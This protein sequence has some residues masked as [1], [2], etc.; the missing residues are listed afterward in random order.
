[1]SRQLKVRLLGADGEPMPESALKSLYASDLHFEPERRRSEIGSDG[2]VEIEAPDGPTA[3]HAKVDV[4]GFGLHWVTADN[5]GQGF[6]PSDTEIDFVAAAAASRLADVK[7]VMAEGGVEWSAPC[8]AH[9]DGAEDQLAMAGAASGAAK[10]Q[11]NLRSLSHGLW[12]GELAVV[13]R[14]QARIAAQGAREGLLFG[15]NAFPRNQRLAEIRARFSQAL[16][17]ATLPFYLARLEPEEGKPD[18]SR[19]DEILAW[20]E[21]EGITPKGHPL[22][23]GNPSGVPKWLEGAD[24]ETEQR[25]CRRV[26]SRSVERYRDRIKIWDAINE[27]HDWANGLGHT[28]E[29]AVEIT[30]IACET[31][32]ENQPDAT[33]IVNNCCPFGEY[34]ASGIVYSGPVLDPVRTP[35]GYMQA[36]M[37]AD[38]DFDVVGVQ[39]YFQARDM[40]AISKLLDEYARFGKRVHITELGIASE[41]GALPPGD[42]REELARVR[43]SWHGPWSERNQADWVEWF[44]TMC[45][46]RPEMEAITWWD[47]AD[48]AFI[49][50]AGFLREDATPK[51]SYY[52][53]RGLLRSWGF[54]E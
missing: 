50:S 21:Q 38:F 41:E 3:L 47:I 2:T 27:A 22:W 30:R 42:E 34:A 16:N 17:F 31:I 1:M 11:C 28:H 53:L 8:R 33:V 51:E 26:V 5:E 9:A 19:I 35:L 46:A 44:Y 40:L 29:Q 12:A 6:G 15:C 4:P 14:A 20:C 23:W 52:R 54:G 18:Y 36:V 48:P 24:W 32:R 25:Q 49:S 37:E 43:G 13:E 10:A 39:L 45:H 7:A